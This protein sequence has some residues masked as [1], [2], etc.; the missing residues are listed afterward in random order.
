MDRRDVYRMIIRIAKAAGIPRYISPHSLR[1]ATITN[2][3]DRC[4][5]PQPSMSLIASPPSPSILT[6][7]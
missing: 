2:A 3:L 6:V 7:R 1:H 5:L 4:P